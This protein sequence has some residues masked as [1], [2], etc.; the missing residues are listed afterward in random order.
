MNSFLRELAD[1][2]FFEETSNVLGYIRQHCQ[3]K[4]GYIPTIILSEDFCPLNEENEDVLVVRFN[5]CNEITIRYR[6]SEI[7]TLTHPSM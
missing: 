7:T 4:L 5:S 6:N 2:L 1:E 3:L